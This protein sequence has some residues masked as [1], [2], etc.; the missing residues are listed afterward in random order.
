M[1]FLLFIILF[2]SC[3]KVDGPSQ[4]INYGLKTTMFTNSVEIID[5]DNV[6]SFNKVSI[7]ASSAFNIKYPLLNSESFIY[8][9]IL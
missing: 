1:F 3:N 5:R 6:N 9:S 2:S 8:P 7:F 4:F